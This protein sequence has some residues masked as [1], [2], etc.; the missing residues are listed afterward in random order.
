MY[1]LPHVLAARSGPSWQ[2]TLST[3]ESLEHV[4]VRYR[5]YFD[6]A[7]SSLGESSL[8]AVSRDPVSTDV[9]VATVL[10]ATADL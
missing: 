10:V 2:D 9:L 3:D 5:C 7:V 8:A 1:V 4:F 6:A